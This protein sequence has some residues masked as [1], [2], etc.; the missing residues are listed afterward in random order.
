MTSLRYIQIDLKHGDVTLLVRGGRNG[1][2][3]IT[4]TADDNPQEV[5][6]RNFADL[7]SRGDGPP[8]TQMIERALQYRDL[9]LADPAVVANLAIRAEARAADSTPPPA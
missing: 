6:D 9:A 4:I 7:A 1:E 3:P 5:L 8:D 2:H